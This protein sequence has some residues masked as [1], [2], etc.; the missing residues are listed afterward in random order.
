MFDFRPNKPEWVK[1]IS[2]SKLDKKRRKKKKTFEF[3]ILPGHENMKVYFGFQRSFDKCF[4]FRPNKPEWDNLIFQA[5]KKKDKKRKEKKRKTFKFAAL[6]LGHE[7]WIVHFGFNEVS[8]EFSTEFRRMFYFRPKKP[9]W[10]KNISLS[11]LGKKEIKN[12]K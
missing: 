12:K 8:F 2:L 9:E 4:Y 11:K 7:N 6:L 1:N 5:R 3:P 10:V